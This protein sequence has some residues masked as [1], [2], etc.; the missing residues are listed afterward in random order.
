MPHGYPSPRRPGP[1]R[2]TF[3]TGDPR[4]QVLTHSAAFNAGTVR[5]LPSVVTVGVNRITG[6]TADVIGSVNPSGSDTTWWVSYGTTLPLP[7][8]STS[9]ADVGS[10]TTP[11]T[12]ATQLTGLT[13]GT[14]YYVA[15][16][17]QSAAGTV[18]GQTVSFVAQAIP[19][20][21]GSTLAGPF[22]TIPHFQVPFSFF[23]VGEASG[24]AVVEQDTLD[25]ILANVNTI[26]E[27]VIGQCPQLPFF[28]RPQPTFAQEPVNTSG[29]VAAIQLQEPRASEDAISQLL[30]DGSWGI[31]LTTSPPNGPSG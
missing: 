17:G 14:T 24:A 27:C 23:A 20:P 10:G 21:A 7:G 18:Y 15:V 3:P 2:G 4:R 29:L 25:E 26:V 30:P 31:A 12:V 19:A 16:V 22:V 6:T 5:S 13:T 8:T 28:G 1:Q 11:T 9:S